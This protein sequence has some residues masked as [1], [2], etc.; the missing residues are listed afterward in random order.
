MS[1]FIMLLIVFILGMFVD[2]IAIS[3]ITLPIFTPIV[4][5]FGID[6]LWFGVLFV[7]AACI[8]YITPPFGSNLFFLKGVTDPKQVSML[9]LYKG[10]TPLS[11]VMVVGLIVCV[12]FPELITWL[13][14]T[15]IK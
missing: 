1:L 7:I 14:N 6:L 12:I 10:A 4:A 5:T 3:M 11:F 2:C 9:D 8:G 15:M 13:P